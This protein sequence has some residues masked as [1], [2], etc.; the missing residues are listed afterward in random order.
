M[1]FGF[2]HGTSIA[3]ALVPLALTLSSCGSG[4]SAYNDPGRTKAPLIN[5]MV[6]K[7]ESRSLTDRVELSGRLDPW[8]DVNVSTELGGVVQH[9]GFDQ[10]QRVSAGQAL[11]RVGTDLMQ[12]SF[13]EAEAARRAAEAAFT[14]TRELFERQ[15]VPRQELI[16]ATSQFEAAKARAALARLRLERSIIKAP[17]AGVAVTREIDPGEVLAPGAPITVI[18]RLDRLKAKA[19]I[20]ENDIAAFR[21]GGEAAITVDAYPDR[22]FAGR[23]TFIGSAVDGT[24]R[25]FPIE[26]AIDNPKGELRSGMIARVALVRQRFEDVV[27]IDR[28]LM[29][30]R[31]SGPVAI[32]LEGHEARVRQLTLG[33]N[34]GNR[35]HV[36]A[37]LSPGEWL[38]VKGQRGLIDGQ[39]VNVVERRQ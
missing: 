7:V 22:A 35:V 39:A 21:V 10:G 32:V 24:T 25:T 26:V 15:H 23:V 3:I 11:A 1:R 31:D 34:E 29:Q 20:P 9:V 36:R 37:G 12:A 28:D 13:D 17:I 18:H 2:L 27:V 5:V 30:E 6:E 38:I 14:K 16:A 8:I 4:G 33:A 19:G